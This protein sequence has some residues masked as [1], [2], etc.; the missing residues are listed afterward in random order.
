MA[1]HDEGGDSSSEVKAHACNVK[2]HL[3]KRRFDEE[4]P[5]AT[6]QPTPKSD[7]TVTADLLPGID[8]TNSDQDH[9]Y[10]ED[11]DSP[12]FPAGEEKPDWHHVG[13]EVAW[14][15]D[16][17]DERDRRLKSS[18]AAIFI[19]AGAGYHSLANERLHLDACSE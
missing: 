5:D 11:F 6:Q 12:L 4:T 3:G 15:T 8:M 2:S 1:Q 7:R 16:G 10:D 17:V 19:H 13:E 18:V 9:E 14:W